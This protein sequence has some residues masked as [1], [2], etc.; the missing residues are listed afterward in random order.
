[1]KEITRL[2]IIL[3]FRGANKDFLGTII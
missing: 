3:R 2:L 1:M